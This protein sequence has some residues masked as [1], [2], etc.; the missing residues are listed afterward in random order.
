MKGPLVF[1]GGVTIRCVGRSR[2]RGYIVPVA[3]LT[4]RDV[5]ILPGETR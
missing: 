5:L 3:W 4:F 1:E 2:G